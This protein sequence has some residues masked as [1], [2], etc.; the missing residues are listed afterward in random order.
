[1][2]NEAVV[3]I[4]LFFL[5]L[6]PSVSSLS[7]IHAIV[8]VLGHVGCVA[9]LNIFFCT[10]PLSMT[11]SLDLVLD[12]HYYTGDYHSRRPCYP[13]GECNARG[14]G[15]G[16]GPAPLPKP[17]TRPCPSPDG[18]VQDAAAGWFVLDLSPD[19]TGGLF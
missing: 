6:R 12:Q 19:S 14:G 17:N 16:G 4:I 10:P 13:E 1:M 8:V 15:H 9:I 18:A 11:L 5:F 2:R 7:R 3:V